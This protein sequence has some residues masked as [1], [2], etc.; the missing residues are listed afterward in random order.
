MIDLSSI[1]GAP[2]NK[3]DRPFIRA[4]L[5]IRCFLDEV[6]NNRMPQALAALL[7]E[8]SYQ[9]WGLRN[10]FQLEVSP[11]PSRFTIDG[12]KHMISTN[13]EEEGK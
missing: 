11:R 5:A 4:R 3:E 2:L 6:P 10:P 8:E 13:M 9:I 7:A 1:Q 12:R